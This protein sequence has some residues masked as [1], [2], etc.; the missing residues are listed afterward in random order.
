[1]AQYSADIR[2]GIT[3][4]TQLNALQ[5]QLEKINKDLVKINKGL[6]AQTLTVNAKGAFRTIDQLEKK[7]N[8]LGR[9]ITINV[10][11]NEQTRSSQSG[12]GGGSSL[13]AIAVGGASQ[14]TQNIKKVREATVEALDAEAKATNKVQQAEQRREQYRNKLI[15][16]Q[17]ELKNLIEERRKIESNLN[18]VKNSATD[19]AETANRN[20]LFGGRINK[21]GSKRSPK[22]AF[23][24]D[25]N[26]VTR[27][28]KKINDLGSSIQDT[29][30]KF[31]NLSSV[32]SK[33]WGAERRRVMEAADAMDK[34]NNKLDENIDKSTKRSRLAKGF[35]AGAG[36]AGASALG[37]VPVLGDAVTGGL[38][39]GFSGASVA[40]GA[41]GGAIV[42]IGVAAVGA[43]GDV[44]AFANALKLQELALANTVATTDEYKTA[45]QAVQS[46]SNDFLVPI[47]D[48]TQQFTKL[49]AAARASGFTVEEVEQVYRGLAAA[50][51]ALGGDAERL[52]GILL[53]TQ[54]VFSKGKVQA[55]E[56]R[57]QIGERL[58][59][60]F[61]LFAKAVGKT[62]AELDKA[63]EKGEVSLKDFVTFTEQLLEKY[64]GNA[65][66]IADAPENAAARLKVAMDNLKKA[67]GPIA[68]EIGNIFLNMA[69]FIIKQLTRLFN[70]INKAR[71]AQATGARREAQDAFFESSRNLQAQQERFRETESG[72]AA[73]DSAATALRNATQGHKMATDAL[74]R[75]NKEY[76]KTQL[77]LPT[78]EPV[79]AK[80]DFTP[81]GKT[82]GGS[83][84]GGGRTTKEYESQAA[85][86]LNQQKYLEGILRLESGRVATTERLAADQDLLMSKLQVQLQYEKD[87]DDLKRE[88]LDDVD[89]ELKATNLLLQ[90]K[91]DLKTIDNEEA[92]RQ[93][94][95]ARSFQDKVD[96]L[97]D[98]IKLEEAVTEQQR[99]QLEYAAARRAIENDGSL[100]GPEKQ[101]LLGL[102][103]RLNQVREANAN[104]VNQYLK[105]LNEELSNTD[106][107]IVQLAQTVET[108]LA[109]A[110]SSAVTGLI[111]G[112]KTAQEAFAEMF[113]NIGKAFV[114]MATQMIAKALVM[115]ALNILL[116]GAA[117]AAATTPTPAFDL[118]NT[119]P[120]G[121]NNIGPM[122]RYE[123][124]GYTG[125]GPRA[126]GLDGR[127]GFMAMVHPDE[128]I[129]DH[130]SPMNRYSGGNS[131]SNGGGP[132]TINFQTQMINNVEYVTKDEAMAMSQA[133]AND[134]A[135]RGASGGH[136]RSMQTLLNSR[137]QRAKLGMS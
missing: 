1:M 17:K 101:T 22:Q 96:A 121:F 43:I 109:S 118:F 31:G 106:A 60:A 26:K 100:S 76:Q 50:N 73:R 104:P 5:K 88:K 134:G 45:L 68:T 97:E 86:L 78:G 53:A 130:R 69:N 48:A 27:L 40:A 65:K 83:K 125:T 74:T 12:G 63:L 103:D 32:T 44:T 39:A 33:Y 61:S 19:R 93:F 111:T 30:K 23:M 128:T 82:G 129:V 25:E 21:D 85:A 98:Q 108:E 42:G 89:R 15:E 14:A 105:Q 64:E 133:A 113:A 110:M 57:G 119:A 99:R 81:A 72:T 137:S 122:T 34:I 18:T 91:I 36:I 132:M 47:G 66:K 127:G 107:M 8:K 87:L 75:A 41:L 28:N 52:Q 135:R 3:G 71:A 126:G 115:K 79:G 46:A 58:P 117:P 55:E 102:Q 10:R 84:G 136:A 38:A 131:P 49:N 59:G 37:G 4:K 24:D 112:T 2:V 116:P 120:E 77:P 114:D 94:D 51:T 56:L 9:T 16:D 13:T 35:G 11:T 67:M 92:Q 95:L 90:L 54:Q 80:P 29:Q 123:G 20:R 62:P 6:K 124:G 7:I 70:F